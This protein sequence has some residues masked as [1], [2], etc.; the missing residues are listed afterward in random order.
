MCGGALLKE[1]CVCGVGGQ[2][3]LKE[4]GGRAGKR[5]ELEG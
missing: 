2:V 3:Q 1:R 4:G 5:R